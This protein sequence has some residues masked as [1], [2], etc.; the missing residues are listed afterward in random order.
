MNKVHIQGSALVPKR[1]RRSSKIAD[2]EINSVMMFFFL[3][4]VKFTDKLA[5]TADYTCA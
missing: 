4:H 5:G 2:R 3:S 1:C